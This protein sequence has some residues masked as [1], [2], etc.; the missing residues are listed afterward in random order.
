MDTIFKDIFT[1]IKQRLHVNE[2]VS[3]NTSLYSLLYELIKETIREI[4]RCEFESEELIFIQSLPRHLLKFIQDC[5][6]YVH[7]LQINVDDEENYSTVLRN[8]TDNIIKYMVCLHALYIL[9]L[10][11]GN[12]KALSIEDY[13]GKAIFESEEEGHQ[14]YTM[15]SIPV[16][17]LCDKIFNNKDIFKI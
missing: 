14:I 3:R 5:T 2:D 16:K 8:F 10:Q 11:P 1:L 4:K 12:K 6:K 9:K 7:L 17:I 15:Y 13:Y